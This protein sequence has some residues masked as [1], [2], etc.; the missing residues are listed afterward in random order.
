VRIDVDNPSETVPG[1]PISLRVKPAYTACPVG[2]A[3]A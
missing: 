2:V 3:G 1:V